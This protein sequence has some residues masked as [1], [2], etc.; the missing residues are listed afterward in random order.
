MS[1]ILKKALA[2]GIINVD[3]TAAVFYDLSGLDKK[4]NSLKA[5]F[6]QG[7]LHAMAIKTNPLTGVLRRLNEKGIA[8][9]AASL[10]EFYIAQKSGF[11]SDRIVFDSP[12]KTRSEL[13]Y[14]LKAGVHINIDSFEELEIVAELKKRIESRSTLGIRLNPQVG[15]GKIKATSVAGEYSKFGIPLRRHRQTLLKAYQDY[16]WLRGVHL[17]IG[18]Q[19][20]SPEMLVDGVRAALD[21]ALEV[22]GKIKSPGRAQAIDIFDIGGGLAAIYR[23]TDKPVSLEQ[24][25]DALRS[26][27]PELFGGQFRLITE[28]GRHIFA[29]IGWAVS[30]VEYVKVETSPST[31][32]N[33]LGAD[34]FIRECYT[35]DDWYHDISACGSTGELKSGETSEYMIAG[36][37][38][39]SGDM[40]ARNIRLPEMESGDYLLIHD[41]GAYTMSMWSRYNSRIIPKVIGYHND[42]DKFEIIKKRETLDRVLDF[43][44]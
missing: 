7:T 26:K 32:I 6:P 16:G 22:N 3:D 30:R 15:T 5:S 18:S 17:H 14:A 20:C 2:E 11:E 38:C 29:N 36:P 24:Y 10:P 4:I 1:R 37:L 21:F 19:G 8:A 41:C 25:A 43:W 13:A 28:F 33:H 27:C 34:M 31:L 12:A 39:F 23:E 9:E 42:G 44:S 40:L 35:P